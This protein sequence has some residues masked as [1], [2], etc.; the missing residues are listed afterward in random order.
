MPSLALVIPP[1][2]VAHTTRRLSTSDLRRR[3]SQVIV[4]DAP[5]TPPLSPGHS[6][7]GLDPIV[8]DSESHYG[9]PERDVRNPTVAIQVEEHGPKPSD[10]AP[11]GPLRLLEDEHMHLQKSGLRLSDFEV[12]GTLGWYPI[13]Y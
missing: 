9:T 7:L 12:R 6:E 4:P 3:E 5:M 8:V 10:A 1:S 13:V 2:S 11:S